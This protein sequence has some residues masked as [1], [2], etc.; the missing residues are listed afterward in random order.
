VPVLDHGSPAREFIP[1]FAVG[2]LYCLS[3]SFEIRISKEFPRAVMV[4]LEYPGPTKISPNL[5][6]SREETAPEMLLFPPAAL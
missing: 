6:A 5:A 4:L 2:P 3:P 1:D